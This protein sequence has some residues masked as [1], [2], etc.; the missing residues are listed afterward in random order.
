MVEVKLFR[1][2]LERGLDKQL[3]EISSEYFIDQ[4]VVFAEEK[5]TCSL[6]SEKQWH[7]YR[8]TGDISI[9]FFK[10]CDCCLDEFTD[11]H[12][13]EFFILLT[14]DTE[15][16]GTEDDDVIWFGD[17]ENTVDI[18]PVIRELVL[19]EEPLKNICSADC[20]GICQHCGANR[21]RENCG[22]NV[23]TVVDNRLENLKQ[24]IK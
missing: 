23:D 22:C 3:F 4:D 16:S 17:A 6:T 8:L 12:T 18:G 20:N 7:G 13:T 14:N 10:I 15:L 5:I 19:V 9:P 21:N 24:I 1:A 11:Q 2:D